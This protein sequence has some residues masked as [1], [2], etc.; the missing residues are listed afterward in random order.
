M[1]KFTK[2]MQNNVIKLIA[3]ERVR[4]EGYAVDGEPQAD[5]SLLNVAQFISSM[6]FFKNISSKQSSTVRAVSADKVVLT[7]T[8][9]SPDGTETRKTEI[10]LTLVGIGSYEFL[11]CL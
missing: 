3:L 9:V 4:L 10:V 11:N 8:S 5:A 6:A 7:T 2:K 1:A